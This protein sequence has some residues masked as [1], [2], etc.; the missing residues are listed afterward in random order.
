MDKWFKEK[1]PIKDVLQRFDKD[2]IDHKKNQEKKVDIVDYDHPIPKDK[3]GSTLLMKAFEFNHEPLVKELIRRKVNPHVKDNQGEAAIHYLFHRKRPSARLLLYYKTLEGDINIQDQEGF[4]PLLT[5]VYGKYHKIVHQ[6]IDLFPNLELNKPNFY[7]ESPLY[8]AVHHE[9]MPLVKHLLSEGADPDQRDS[10]DYDSIMLACEKGSFQLFKLLYLYNLPQSYI[11]SVSIRRIRLLRQS[12][13]TEWNALMLAVRSEMIEVV[14]MVQDVYPDLDLMNNDNQSVWDIAKK[15]T[16][17]RAFKKLFEKMHKKYYD[18]LQKEPKTLDQQKRALQNILR[19]DQ[20]LVYDTDVA[21]FESPKVD[22][23]EET[24]KMVVEEKLQK[25]CVN[26]VDKTH[27]LED[28][29]S[30]FIDENQFECYVRKNLLK[31][32][33]DQ[34]HIYEKKKRKI[35]KDQPV[36]R[37]PYSKRYLSSQAYYQVYHHPHQKYWKVVNPHESHITSEKTP[38]SIYDVE[39][40]KVV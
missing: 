20:G 1:R 29:V 40:V 15:T 22:Q 18:F 27:D 38:I 33:H 36:F 30:F 39:V 12:A 19:Y 23:L 2:Y 11:P 17:A 9:D 10:D 31:S 5:A 6:M 13:C 16:K 7:G 26:D 8:V 24:K 4:T 37:L 3:K 14:E 32:F 25:L 35:K 34:T 28:Y 21:L